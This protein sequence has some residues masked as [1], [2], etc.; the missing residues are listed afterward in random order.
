[1]FI[2]S[3]EIKL[4]SEEMCNFIVSE[5]C[6]LYEL[7]LCYVVELVREELEGEEVK[8]VNGVNDF[9]FGKDGVNI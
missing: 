3:G 2:E 5:G 9:I 1:M 4:F 7:Y 6:D 8:R